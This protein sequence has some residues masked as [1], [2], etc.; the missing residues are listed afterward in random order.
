MGEHFR[1]C[2]AANNMSLL[3]NIADG[4]FDFTHRWNA[5]DAVVLPGGPTARAPNPDREVFTYTEPGTDIRPLSE[6]PDSGNRGYVSNSSEGLVPLVAS[7]SPGMVMR[8]TENPG[9][10]VGAVT[11]RPI[12]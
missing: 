7:D 12:M 4:T 6:L 9:W 5:R 1:N 11:N 3:T 10:H 2:V 8:V